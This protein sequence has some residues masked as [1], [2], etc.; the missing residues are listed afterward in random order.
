MAKKKAA[1]SSAKKDD[2]RLEQAMEE[3][4]TIVADLEAGQEP[5]DQSLAQFERGMELLRL[6]HQQL[7][8]AAQR[9]EIVTRVD[10]KGQVHTQP[11]DATSTLDRNA[12]D[13]DDSDDETPAKLF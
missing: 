5:L 3:L 1:K 8:D 9:I 2:I 11:F 10:Q 12:G 4:Q 7:E 6:C 13:I